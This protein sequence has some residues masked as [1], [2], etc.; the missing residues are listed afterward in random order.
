MGPRSSIDNKDRAM[1]KK[2]FLYCINNILEDFPIKILQ[3]TVGWRSWV[4]VAT[5]RLCC[6]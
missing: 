2:T 6:A 5:R 3:G 1:E 4:G